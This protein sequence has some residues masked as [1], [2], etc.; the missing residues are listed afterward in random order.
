MGL[1]YL[2]MRL[3]SRSYPLFYL[4]LDRPTNWGLKSEVAERQTK[5]EKEEN[6]AHFTSTYQLGILVY[7][8]HFFFNAI[9]T[10]VRWR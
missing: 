2:D 5:R 7:S 4:S 6:V 3:R 1:A 9:S 8:N 10:K